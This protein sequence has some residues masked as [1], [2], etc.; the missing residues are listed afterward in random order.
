[1]RFWSMMWVAPNDL[2]YSACFKL[3]EVTT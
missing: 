2:R 3:A 1:V